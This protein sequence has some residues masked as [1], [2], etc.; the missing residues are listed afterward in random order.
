MYKN[1]TSEDE[2]MDELVAAASSHP[3]DVEDEIAATT[4]ARFSPR[5]ENH[6][7]DGMVISREM[8]TTSHKATASMM[9]KEFGDMGQFFWSRLDRFEE[10]QARLITEVNELRVIA[11]AGKQGAIC[12]TRS[13]PLARYEIKLEKSTPCALWVFD[14]D[15]ITKTLHMKLPHFRI[16][17][18]SEGG[19]FVDKVSAAVQ[20][21]LF[22]LQTSQRRAVFSSGIG[23]RYTGFHFNIMMNV[24]CNVEQ[25]RFKRFIRKEFENGAA[26]P[27]S[28]ARNAESNVEGPTPP[29]PPGVTQIRPPIW[30]EPELIRLRHVEDARQRVESNVAPQDRGSQQ[31]SDRQSSKRVWLAMKDTP[32]KGDIARFGSLKVYRLV[33]TGLYYGREKAKLVLFEKVMYLLILLGIF[34]CGVDK[35]KR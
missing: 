3:V 34:V 12:H 26:A 27:D 18:A 11:S 10:N 32:D 22:G 21:I 19:A 5:K 16:S 29:L 20:A 9:A 7:F 25:N 13:T 33:T 8:L 1:A 35:K 31:N 6:D 23:R 4:P 28:G 15:T 24:I 2:D 14:V 17:I 30:L